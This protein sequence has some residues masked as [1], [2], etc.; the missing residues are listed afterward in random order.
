MAYGRNLYYV[1]GHLGLSEVL[2]SPEKVMTKPDFKTA[3]GWANYVAMDE[4]G[5]WYWFEKRPHIQNLTWDS[6]K[7][8]VVRALVV[9]EEWQD[10]LHM[11]TREITGIRP[12]PADDD[13]DV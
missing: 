12:V 11:V 13:E 5:E 6:D 4:C 9:K 8:K 2:L 3:P 7:G 10:S 1:S